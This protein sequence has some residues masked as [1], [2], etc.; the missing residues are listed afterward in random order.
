MVK[1]DDIINLISPLLSDDICD[2]FSLPKYY[3]D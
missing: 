2:F 1:T 3:T